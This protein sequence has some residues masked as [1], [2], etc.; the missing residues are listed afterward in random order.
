MKSH[1][2]II[3]LVLLAIPINT[4]AQW[5]SN[6]PSITFIP[7]P[8]QNCC[9]DIEIFNSAMW[10]GH[11]N[12]FRINTDQNNQQQT[13]I[14]SANPLLGYSTNPSIIPPQI[15][16]LNWNKD[17]S[18]FPFHPEI[19]GRICFTQHSVQNNFTIMIM[20]S[21][22]GGNSFID[23]SWLVNL[24]C[25]PVGCES[26]V[27]DFTMEDTLC[28]NGSITMD[29]S[30][31]MHET[32]YRVSVQKLGSTVP[33]INE[34]FTGEAGVFDLKTWYQNKGATFEC[35]NYYRIKLGVKNSCTDLTEINKLLFIK[36]CDTC[37]GT[38]KAPPSI[39]YIVGNYPVIP[40]VSVSNFP[41]TGAYGWQ[42]IPDDPGQCPGGTGSITGTGPFN[43]TLNQRITANCTYTLK[44]WRGDCIAQTQ[45]R[46]IPCPCD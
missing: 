16:Q 11:W 46:L 33:E 43:I 41:G 34:W 1:I 25:D 23:N 21:T 39:F 22:N 17:Q 30:S 37:T 20:W 6:P 12:C 31:S 10:W 27:P 40:R 7:V 3:F 26:A 9:F 32:N 14:I 42:L 24:I 44:I 45:L 38:I 29:G 5:Y 15:T 4:N 36:C 28:D 19:V 2:Y 35:G 8:G 18:H 13:Y